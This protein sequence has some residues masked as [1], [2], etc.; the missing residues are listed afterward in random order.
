MMTL[1]GVLIDTPVSYTPAK[2]EA[3]RPNGLGVITNRNSLRDR[4]LL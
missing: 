3:D 1:V 4:V 2:F